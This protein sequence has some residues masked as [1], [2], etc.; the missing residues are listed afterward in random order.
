MGLGD[1]QGLCVSEVAWRPGGPGSWGR[2]D[3]PDKSVTRPQPALEPFA[4]VLSSHLLALR[5]PV[6]PSPHHEQSDR[7]WSLLD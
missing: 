7:F 2:K 3:P 4:L 5:A 6:R 1:S